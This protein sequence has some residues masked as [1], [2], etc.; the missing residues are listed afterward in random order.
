M[1]PRFTSSILRLFIVLLTLFGSQTVALG[2]IDAEFVATNKAPKVLFGQPN[3]KSTFA[4]GPFKGKSINEVSQG[5]RNGTISPD[6]LPLDVII[7][8][9]TC[10]PIARL[11][12][13]AKI[14]E[15]H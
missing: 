15:K 13:G 1:P 11:P 12:C 3:V 6:Q 2:Q 4:N 8:N 14:D 7:S 9:P 5:L 10:Q